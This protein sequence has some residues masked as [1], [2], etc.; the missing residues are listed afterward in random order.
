MNIAIIGSNGYVGKEIVKAINKIKEYKP[1]SVTR[2]DNLAD[3]VKVADIVIHAANPAKRFRAE[4][5]PKRD[6][7]ET[8]FKTDNILK[9]FRKKVILISSI[10]CRTQLDTNYGRNRRACELLVLQNNGI[11]VRLG[12]MFGGNR[13]QDVLHDILRGNKIYVSA[14][15][16]YAYANVSW[17]GQKIVELLDREHPQIIEIG[18]RNSISLEKIKIHFNSNSNFSGYDDTQEPINCYDGPDANQVIKYA[19]CE[20]KKL[21]HIKSND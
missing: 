6:F 2:N 7:I 13:E 8:V 16:R 19:E 10:S 18:A 12:P 1:I 4:N 21:A 14:K 20:Y 5:D 17:C 3:K 15:T 11:V 9:I